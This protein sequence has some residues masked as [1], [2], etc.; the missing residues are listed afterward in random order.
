MKIL[1]FEKE[2]NLRNSG[3][4]AGYLYN[5][6]EF[7]KQHPCDE[8]EFLKDVG[9]EETW[10]SRISSFMLF[11]MLYFTKGLPRLNYLV[12]VITNFIYSRHLSEKAFEYL[13]SFD[14]IHVHYG[15][16]L[17][18]YFNRTK[19][20][21]KL[22]L[23]SHCP[24]PAF[25]EMS[26]HPKVRPFIQRHPKWRNWFLRREVKV[27]DICDYIMF[28]VPQAREPY[29]NASDIYKSKFQEVNSKFFY[30]PTALNSVDKIEGNEHYTDKLDI[31]EQTLRI[32]YIGRHTPVKGYDFLKE[33][34]KKSL[35]SLEDIVYLIGGMKNCTIGLKHPMWHELGWVKTPL[36]LNETDVFVLPNRETY[37]DL[38]LLEVLRQGTPV[39]I[40]RTGG[41]KWF[42]DKGVEGIFFFDYGDID[43]FVAK[44]KEIQILKRQG[45]LEEYNKSNRL[46]FSKTFG[47]ERYITNYIE[48]I[49]GRI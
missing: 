15:P 17:Y 29:E 4:P 19:I 35:E 22:I 30:V 14:A 20:R 27:Y 49:R 46:F 25:D 2:Q 26:S 16:T 23:T 41:N 39:L 1:I 43:D 33:A 7:I 8:I 31:T 3:G 32:C 24:E 5:I 13:N 12:A 28:P 48:Q 10:Y 40:S 37:F 36:L 9:L 47:M 34:G 42:E 45:K 18:Q 44:L 38:V 6:S 21:G 11:L